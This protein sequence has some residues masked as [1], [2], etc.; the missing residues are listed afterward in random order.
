MSTTQPFSSQHNLA[1][2]L[3]KSSMPRTNETSVDWDALLE[4][5]RKLFPGELEVTAEFD[6]EHPEHNFT[7]VHVS[8]PGEIDSIVDRELQWVA[9]LNQ[10]APGVPGIRLSIEPRP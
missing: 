4:A 3:G 1:V 10:L 7:V 9:V 6:P 5:T 8:A 2:P